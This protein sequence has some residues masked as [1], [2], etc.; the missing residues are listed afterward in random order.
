MTWDDPFE[1]VQQ[2][3]KKFL[4]EWGDAQW[5]GGHIAFGDYNLSDISIDWCI[6]RLEAQHKATVAFLR[7]LKTKYSE[8]VRDSYWE[9]FE[10]RMAANKD[11]NSKD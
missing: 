9:Y 1:P 6:E 2:D 8:E 3:I 11:D 10:K 4:E 7:E 5:A